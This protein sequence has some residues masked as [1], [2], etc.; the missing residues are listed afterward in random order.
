RPVVPVFR[1]GP[2]LGRPED[3]DQISVSGRELEGRELFARH[4]PHLLPD[5]RPRLSDQIAADEVQLDA[6]LRICMRRG[7]Y[8]L[9]DA[10]ANV[11]LLAQLALETRRQ[12]FAG[13]ALAAGKFPVAREVYAFL[14]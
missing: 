2:P 1:R 6:P 13:L 7:E 5:E 9:A 3:P 10:R 8:F 4:P 14:P 11:E 12:R